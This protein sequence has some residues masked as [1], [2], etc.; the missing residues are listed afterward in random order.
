MDFME[1]VCS[2]VLTSET[3]NHSDDQEILVNA[4]HT[5]NCH[6]VLRVDVAG[7]AYCPFMKSLRRSFVWSDIRELRCYAKNWKL[8]CP[9]TKLEYQIS[10]LELW[11]GNNICWGWAWIKNHRVAVCSTVTWWSPWT[12]KEAE[13]ATPEKD[14]EFGVLLE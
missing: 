14:L 10:V 1:Q 9:K 11:R 4:F 12:L 2:F 5:N 13:H 3:Q 6:R 7:N 8:L